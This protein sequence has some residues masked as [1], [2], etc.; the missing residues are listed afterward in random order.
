MDTRRP[1]CSLA[2]AGVALERR[3]GRP[4]G[5]HRGLA[6]GSVPRGAGHQGGRPDV[7][8][9]VSFT[10]ATASWVTTSVRSSS[11]ASPG[12][13]VPSSRVPRSSTGCP[14]RCATRPWGARDRPALD[15]LERRNLLVIPLDRRGEWYRYH[16]LFRELLHAELLRRESE[17]VPELHIVPRRGT[18]RTTFPRRPSSTLARGRHRSGGT[19]RPQRSPTG[20]GERAP[21]HSAALDG[22]V[23]RRRL[24][25]PSR[26]S[27]CTE[28]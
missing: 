18:R 24:I 28:R 22:V 26:R 16:Q 5:A 25:E 13:E 9:E 11:I 8:V 3:S 4:R 2:G 19:S 20:V 10:G 12:R 15:R 6:G 23:L 1:V 7:D 14:G 17:I 27:P 21:G